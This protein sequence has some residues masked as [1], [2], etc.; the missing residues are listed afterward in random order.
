MT[1]VSPNKP[2]PSFGQ[3]LLQFLQSPMAQGLS[4]G[5]LASSGP[6]PIPQSFG[7]ALGAGLLQGQQLESNERKMKVNEGNLAETIRH[8]KSMEEMQRVTSE[9][10]R[11]KLANDLKTQQMLIEKINSM[12]DSGDVAPEEAQ[13][14]IVEMQAPYSPAEPN[15]TPSLNDLISGPQQNLPNSPVMQ[16][17]MPSLPEF[18]P[19]ATPKPKSNKRKLS[20]EQADRAKLLAAG[21]KKEVVDTLY[22]DESQNLTGLPQEYASYDALER[23]HGKDHPLVQQT[24]RALDARLEAQ[25]QMT[26]NREKYL[27]TADKRASTAL[28]K[29][30]QE[31]E[32]ARA[33]FLPGTNGTVQLTPEQQQAVVQ[34]YELKIQKE[35]SDQDSRKRA[36]FASNIDKTIKQIDVDSLV[37]YSGAMGA[38][39]KK[40]EQGKAL[41]GNESEEYAKYLE[42]LTAVETLAMQVRQFYGE[43]ITPSAKKAIDDLVNPATWAS[44]PRL[45]KRQFEKIK[46]ILELETETFRGALQGTGEFKQQKKSEKE[47]VIDNDPLGLRKK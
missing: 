26:K 47:S 40:L 35:V 14:A 33:G 2:P 9:L 8:N 36:L 43:S 10:K 25:E 18:A 46:D 29:A 17:Q 22:P 13:N 1:W 6:S 27:E 15:F 7:S 24:K 31:L 44:N 38:I 39:N 34:Q 11:A 12:V 19:E 45:A 37:Q 30:Q 42:N 23:R 16:A 28:G 41:T 21:V 5:L 4:A 32:E 20:A 3:G